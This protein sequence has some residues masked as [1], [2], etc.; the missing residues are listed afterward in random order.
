ME[1]WKFIIF[2]FCAYLL[3]TQL[4]SSKICVT[5]CKEGVEVLPLLWFIVVV[6]PFVPSG[7]HGIGEASPSD[8]VG[9]DLSRTTYFTEYTTHK[10]AR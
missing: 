10:W 8:S 7:L 4:S 6:H 5:I 3:P 1:S 9:S 2:N